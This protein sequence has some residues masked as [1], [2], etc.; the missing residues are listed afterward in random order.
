MKA[1]VLHKFGDIP[2][3]EDFP[4]PVPNQDEVLIKVK[5]IAF[6]NIHKM[7]AEGEHFARHQFL[8]ELPAIVGFDG[9]GEL[10]NGQLVGFGGT[11]APYGSMAEKTVVPKTNTISIPEGVDAVTAAVLPSSALTSL[12]PFQWGAKLQHGE[13]VL[14]NG[15]TG[16]SGKLAVQIAKLLGAGR[17][18]GTGR[19]RESLKKVMELGADAVID[20]KQPDEQ[21]ADSFIKEAKD[22]YDII[23]DFLWGRPTEVLIKTLIPD[24]IGYVGNRIRLVQ[25]GEAAGETISLPA[26]SLRNSGLEIIGA[27]AG[28]TPEAMN[29]STNQVWEWIKDNK[30]SMDIEKVPL[31]D[32]ESAWKRTDFKGKRIVI[33]P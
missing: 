32:I 5:A 27:S 29:E 21:L 1:A 22:G 31:K 18:V 30:L 4:V 3:Y 7:M 17:I 25:V 10:S 26:S 15:A 33:V 12:F 24:E 28:M 13:T 19:N 23:L 16:V 6:E 11:K 2:R 14:I 20:L 9:I 8:T